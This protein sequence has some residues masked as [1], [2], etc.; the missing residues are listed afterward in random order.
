MAQTVREK[1]RREIEQLLAE[2]PQEQWDDPDVRGVLYEFVP[3]HRSSSV[4]IMTREDDPL[5]IGGWKYYYSADSDGSLIQ[6]EF[7]AWHNE[8]GNKRLVFHHLLIEAA[9][10]LL[11]I[12]FTPFINPA[13]PTPVLNLR[14][15]NAIDDDFCL[16]KTFLLQVYDPDRSFRFNYCEYVMARRLETPP[17]P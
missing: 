17:A 10:A 5:D 12:D 14:F 16:N 8:T 6:A 13:L 9:E 3:W 15:W 1:F 4:T 2:V 11:S 7:D